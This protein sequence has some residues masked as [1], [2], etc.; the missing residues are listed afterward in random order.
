MIDFRDRLSA[1]DWAAI[2]EVLAGDGLLLVPTETVYG[3]ACAALRPAAV[4][5]LKRLKGRESGKPLQLLVA[6]PGAARKCAADWPPAAE[7]LAS[8]GWPGALTLVLTAADTVPADLRAPDGTVGLRCPDHALLRELMAR[9]GS[10]AASSANLPGKPPALDCEAAVKA[11][12]NAVELALD[13][14]PVS[15][16]V[17]STVVR[18]EADSLEILRIGAWSEQEVR[19]VAAG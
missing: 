15:G 5:R 2:G 4:A 8:A 3:V 17:A 1:Q 12:G 9:H 16:G 10:L 18:V 14:G 13:G 7:R 19:R 6:S 11:L